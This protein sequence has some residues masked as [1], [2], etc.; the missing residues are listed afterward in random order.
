ML[1]WK[2]QT[3]EFMRTTAYLMI[4]LISMTGT[5][6][7]A[8]T[9]DMAEPEDIPVARSSVPDEEEVK[10]AYESAFSSL[11]S[12]PSKDEEE[13]D[14]SEAWRRSQEK[15]DGFNIDNLSTAEGAPELERVAMPEP[16]VQPKRQALRRE[17]ASAPVKSS[18]GSVEEVPMPEGAVD[19]NAEINRSSQQESSDS[20]PSLSAKERRALILRTIADN[21]RDL[22]ACYHEGLRKKSDMKGK[23]VLGWSM[24]NLGRV[25]GVEV[26]SSQLKNQQ[27]EKCMTERLAGW[28]F[29]RQAKIAGSKDRM[30]HTFHF[31]PE[32]E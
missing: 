25:S 16:K 9:F 31:V 6:W 3:G 4:F 8:E 19:F 1:A 10:G 15:S 29:P 22:K 24:D 21:Y 13:V 20:G 18:A 17:P 2:D 26:Q 23:V 11:R 28:R 32:N 30:T 12:K 7:A 27:V 5:S 14:P